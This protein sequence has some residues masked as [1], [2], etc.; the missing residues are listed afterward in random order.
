MNLLKINANVLTSEIRAGIYVCFFRDILINRIRIIN[1]TQFI[2]INRFYE[3]YT[4]NRYPH[5]HFNTLKSLPED[6]PSC[7]L[8]PGSSVSWHY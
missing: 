5:I 7:S 1:E 3:D 2:N 6:N 8:Y 4:K